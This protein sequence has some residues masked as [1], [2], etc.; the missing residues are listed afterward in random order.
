MSGSGVV[1]EELLRVTAVGAE[2]A[3]G[4]AG[5]ESGRK[6]PTPGEIRFAEGAFDPDVD[7]EEPEPLAGEE[8]DAGG[9]L[10]TDAG[11]AGEAGEGGL[12]G[13]VGIGE[14]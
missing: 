10:G 12:I 5:E 11:G 13:H 9:D 14:E 6:F 8:Q 2:V 1:E 3:V 4:E 7:R